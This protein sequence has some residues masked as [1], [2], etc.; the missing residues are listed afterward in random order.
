M[1]ASP[2]FFH[3]NGAESKSILPG[4][5]IGVTIRILEL[6]GKNRSFG[7]VAS[8]FRETPKV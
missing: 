5:Y 3:V 4:G 2:V 1:V 8:P 7:K 6:F